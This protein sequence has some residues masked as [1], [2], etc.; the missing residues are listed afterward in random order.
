M[1]APRSCRA[2]FDPSRLV[3]Y[4]PGALPRRPLHPEGFESYARSTFNG[5][6]AILQSEGPEARVQADID[7]PFSHACHTLLEADAMLQH[8]GSHPVEQN[9]ETRTGYSATS[10]QQRIGRDTS[11]LDQSCRGPTSDTD[12]IDQAA[13][14]PPPS[15]LSFRPVERQTTPLR[16][17][18]MTHPDCNTQDYRA[19]SP[20][21]EACSPVLC[22]R[23]QGQLTTETLGQDQATQPPT[24]V[25][26][27]DLGLLEPPMTISFRPVVTR[28]FPRQALPRMSPLRTV[29]CGTD[30]AVAQPY[31]GP[32]STVPPEAAAAMAQPLATQTTRLQPND[33]SSRNQLARSGLFCP[34]AFSGSGDPR[35][36]L[37]QFNLWA[38]FHNLDDAGAQSAFGLLMR[39]QAAVWFKTAKSSEGQ[40]LKQLLDLF[41]QRYTR[42]EKP[43]R[44]LSNLGTRNSR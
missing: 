28:H 10:I 39:D 15:H 1:D 12:L 24:F 40:S 44:E 31:A 13:L 36:F 34:Q 3:Q 8:Q 42:Q 20:L 18:P 32:P 22:N 23:R 7:D 33:I 17:Y 38:E 26:R 29:A 21:S 43:W 6:Q 41:L 19:L 37:R 2:L 4:G 5:Q 16:Q 30:E 11:P 25:S 14:P 9:A 35:E 27:Y